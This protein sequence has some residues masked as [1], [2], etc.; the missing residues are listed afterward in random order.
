MHQGSLD[1]RDLFPEAIRLIRECA[2]KAIILENVKGLFSDKFL[3]YRN[4]IASSLSRLGYHCEW[5]LLNACEFGVPQNRN[6]TILVGIKKVISREI[7]WPDA[8]ITKP[9]TVGEALFELMKSN[10]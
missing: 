5:K 3:E 1:D 10:G 9:I 6:R 8:S 4:K 2:P 7:I